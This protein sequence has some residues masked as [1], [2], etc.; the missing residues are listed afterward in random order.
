MSLS[1][2]CPPCNRT[3]KAPQS[4]AGRLL[5]CPGCRERITV[6]S[7]Q[8]APAA[9]PFDF[10]ADGQ[11]KPERAKPKRGGG[12]TVERLAAVVFLLVVFFGMLGGA[13]YCGYRFVYLPKAIKQRKHRK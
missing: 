13:G 10:Q 11:G 12:M 2:A 6:P 9:D 5:T 3:L 4:A 8:P 7:G 1:L